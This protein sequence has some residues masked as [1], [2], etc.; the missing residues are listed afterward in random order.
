[1]IGVRLNM[2]ILRDAA[3]EAGTWA[4]LQR[5]F[6]EH[7]PVLL[8]HYVGPPKRAAAERSMSQQLFKR[9]VSWLAR[10][11]YVGICPSDWLAWCHQAKPLPSR[12]VLFTFCGL[13]SDLT[14]DSPA[15]RII[16]DFGFGAAVL[17]GQDRAED[18][19]DRE[20][21]KSPDKI[22]HWKS[23]RVEFCWT[24]IQPVAK[25]SATEEAVRISENDFVRC[26][27]LRETSFDCRRQSSPDRSPSSRCNSGELA[28]GREEGLN[29]IRTDLHRLRCTTVEPD[30]NVFDLV[31]RVWFGRSFGWMRSRT[32]R[33]RNSC[34]D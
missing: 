18:S 28:F 32:K 21:A 24:I 22:E 3:R 11:G 10:H 8:Y 34:G 4:N 33:R 31:C 14:E 2:T 20:S 6:G 26:L 12:P 30:D 15:L 17:F 27:T 25:Q 19:C 9:Q 23:Q 13:C 29:D 7:L 1:L 5:T 16:R